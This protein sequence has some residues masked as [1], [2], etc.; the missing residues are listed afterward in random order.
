MNEKE[1]RKIGHKKGNG[2]EKMERK[3]EWERRGKKAEQQ[4]KEQ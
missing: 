2:E 1:R 4:K 3:G